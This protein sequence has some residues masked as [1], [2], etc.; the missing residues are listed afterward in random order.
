MTGS[1]RA[2]MLNNKSCIAFAVD[3]RLHHIID[4]ATFKAQ[5]TQPWKKSA[6]TSNR[7]PYS[8]PRHL[9]QQILCSFKCGYCILGI[10]QRFYHESRCWSRAGDGMSRQIKAKDECNYLL[11]PILNLCSGTPSSSKIIRLHITL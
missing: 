9:G 8:R 4:A 11:I 1:P 6:A 5:S 3:L 2:R 10:A 7:S